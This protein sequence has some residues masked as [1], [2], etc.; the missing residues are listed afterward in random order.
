MIAKDINKK[1]GALNG[2]GVSN[3]VASN[4]SINSNKDF[5]GDEIVITEKKEKKQRCPNCTQEILDDEFIAHSL[6]C[7]RNKIRCKKCGEMIE[8]K[9]R[10]E[11]LLEWRSVE[12]S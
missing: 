12:V 3:K 1:R 11:H 4:V 2:K 7:L 8:E 10:K 9:N 5:F 6:N